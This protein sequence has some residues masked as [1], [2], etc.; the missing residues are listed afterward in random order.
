MWL[1]LFSHYIIRQ[2]CVQ[3]SSLMTPFFIVGVKFSFV[4]NFEISLFVRRS[5][6]GVVV[7]SFFQRPLK[8]PLVQEARAS[9]RI[10]L[11]TIYISQHFIFIYRMTPLLWA[12]SGAQSVANCTPDDINCLSF[13]AGRCVLVRSNFPS[14]TYVNNFALWLFAHFS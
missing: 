12:A 8:K 1:E 4:T 6:G 2:L 11:Y 5:Q 9:K 14:K 3:S 10:F 7:V 13:K